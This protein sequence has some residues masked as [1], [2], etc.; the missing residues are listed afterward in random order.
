MAR[1]TANAFDVVCRQDRDGK[2][3]EAPQNKKQQ[4]ATGLLRDKLFEQDFAGLIS[5]R[6]SIILGP[7]SRY[8]V[9]D[10]LPHM[11][12]V[13]HASRPG[14]LSAFYAFSAMDFAQLKDFTLI[15]NEHTCRLQKPK[16]IRISPAFVP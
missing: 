12:I 2:L 13:S 9:A 16:A 10:I 6:A 8:G 1:S 7:I 15:K 3:G 14:L 11:K 4:V 5:V